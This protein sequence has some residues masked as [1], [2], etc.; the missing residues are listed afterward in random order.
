M[1]SQIT[2]QLDIRE[3]EL[4][5]L[6]NS[7]V[8]VGVDD[9]LKVEVKPLDIGD[10]I[11]YDEEAQ[12]ELLIIERKT[13]QDLNSS[14]TDG[15][16][17]EQSY[18]LTNACPEIHNHNIIY[19]IEGTV[20]QPPPIKAIRFKNNIDMSRIFSAM[21]S[22]N[23]YKGFSLFR[24]FDINETAL[25]IHNTAKKLSKEKKV[26]YYGGA[27]TPQGEGAEGAQE[28]EKG[29]KG[30]SYA[31]VVKRTKK[32][33]ITR[34]NIGEI[35]LCQIPY[36]SNVTA[37][38]IMKEFASFAEL[39]AA[40]REKAEEALNGIKYEDF[41]GKKRAISKKCISSIISFIGV[42]AQDGH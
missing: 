17:E 16:Y 20:P 40:I 27:D 39:M 35:F 28:E 2:I 18:R 25:F 12:K 31:T 14:I 21:F 6:I 5:S 4:I 30:N 29:E 19:L 1:P 32:D 37:A 15:R 8:G 38:A 42:Q 36:V 7:K 11:L 41:K 10:I 22:L 33:N 3:T 23:Y 13:I 34:E 26:A 24:T 9:S